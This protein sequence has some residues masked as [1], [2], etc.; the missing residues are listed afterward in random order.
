MILLF[1]VMSAHSYTLIYFMLIAYFN[2]LNALGIS[3]IIFY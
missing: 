1:D 2:T 3:E